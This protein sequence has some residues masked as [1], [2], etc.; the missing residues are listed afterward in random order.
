MHRELLDPEK[1]DPFSLFLETA[2][3][4]YCQYNDS[5]RI[6]CNMFGM[7]ILLVDVLY[8]WGLEF[9]RL[10][11][12]GFHTMILEKDDV[13]SCVASVRWGLPQCVTGNS[14]SCR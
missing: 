14:I 6:F 3:I 11:Y 5:E 2:K 10:I 4:T 13:I 9:A 1:V 7:C 12:E 8:N